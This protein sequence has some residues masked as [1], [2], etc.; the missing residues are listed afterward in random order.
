MNLQVIQTLE[1]LQNSFDTSL[2]ILSTNY[3]ELIDNVQILVNPMV[4]EIKEVPYQDYSDQVLHFVEVNYITLLLCSILVIT[5]FTMINQYRNFTNLI[6]KLEDTETIEMFKM[7]NRNRHLEMKLDETESKLELVQEQLQKEENVVNT[8][9]KLRMGK[10]GFFVINR[11]NLNREIRNQMRQLEAE[12][13][14][15]GR[16]LVHMKHLN[17]FNVKNVIL[18]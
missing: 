15:N 9:R 10:N 6:N 17:R 4:N 1:F 16:Y 13:L 11:K 5:L 2:S 7:R 12:Y 8:I 14:S 3:H 18:N